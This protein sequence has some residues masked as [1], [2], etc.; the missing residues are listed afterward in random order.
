MKKEL[1]VWYKKQR[2]GGVTYWQDKFEE[3]QPEIGEALDMYGLRLIELAHLAYRKSESEREKKL[4]K[5]FVE[6]IGPV[7]AEKVKDAD[8]LV[9]AAKGRKGLSFSEMTAMGRE[10]QKE[11]GKKVSFVRHQTHSSSF[12]PDVASS[13]GSR[14]SFT[15]L[16]RSDPQR[17]FVSRRSNRSPSQA[18]HA[19]SRS[20]GKTC[21]YCKKPGHIKSE[22][23]RASGLC[24]ICGKQHQMVDCSKYNPNFKKGKEV[25]TSTRCSKA[26]NL[27]DQALLRRGQQQG[28][29]K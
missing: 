21:F 26:E 23:W 9:R 16:P 13:Q 24:L 18:S 25:Q 7:I 2:I 20:S 4:K 8:R 22:C 19:S 3:A 1:L 29:R 10:L 15:G 17:T 5:H 14:A 28:S 6:T 12:C 11:E 27:N